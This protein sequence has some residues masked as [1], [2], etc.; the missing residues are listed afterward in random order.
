MIGTRLCPP[1]STRPSC[2]ATSAKIVSASS[3]VLRHVADEGGG[4]HAANLLA[5]Q[6]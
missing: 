6:G 1:A 3:S 2:G 5:A 4:F